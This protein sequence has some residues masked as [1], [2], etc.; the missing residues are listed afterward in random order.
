MNCNLGESSDVNIR[1][2]QIEDYDPLMVLWNES[3][4]PCRPKG[5]DSREKIAR[6]IE[7]LN[8][9][10]LIAEMDGQIVGSIFGTH[11]GRKGWINRLA[12][13]PAYRKR[14][15]AS[16]LVAEA[17]SRFSE[18]GIDI[19]ACLIEEW[20][21]VSMEVFEKLGFKRHTDIIYFSKRKSPDV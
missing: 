10:F 5:R 16:K 12:V 11:E 6:E 3:R 13:S 19:V 17:E 8:A 18:H 4:L 14:G 20:N 2:F 1:E 7:H 15:I 21:T 9:V